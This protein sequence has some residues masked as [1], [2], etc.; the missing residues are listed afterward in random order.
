MPGSREAS[1][2]ATCLLSFVR[3]SP[4]VTACHRT[5]SGNPLLVRQLLQA[6]VTAGVKPDAS[7]AQAVLAV[8]SRAVSS[9]VLLRLR[10]MPEKCRAV[11]P[12]R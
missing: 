10:R 6:L 3:S 4:V 7:H 9:Q 5:T 12:P 2:C 1:T 8:G 11:E